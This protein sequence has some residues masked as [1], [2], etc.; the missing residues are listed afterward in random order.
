MEEVGDNLILS[1][2]AV[3]RFKDSNPSSWEEPFPYKQKQ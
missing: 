1:L 3:A 2:F